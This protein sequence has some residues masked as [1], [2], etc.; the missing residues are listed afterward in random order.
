MAF[1]HILISRKPVD[2]GTAMEESHNELCRREERIAGAAPMLLEALI[3]LVEA[4]ESGDIPS[5]TITAARSAIAKTG[6][7]V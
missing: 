6:V 7:D 1:K 5:S 3:D 4:H 2:L